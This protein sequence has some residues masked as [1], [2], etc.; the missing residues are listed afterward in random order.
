[1]FTTCDSFIDQQLRFMSEKFDKDKNAGDLLNLDEIVTSS[2]GCE[3][4]HAISW[5]DVKNVL[6]PV[7]LYPMEHFILLRLN[8]D[9]RVLY[10]YNSWEREDSVQRSH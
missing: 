4:G 9:E 1:M 8:F 7:H 5:A 10:I 3:G 6:I 2:L